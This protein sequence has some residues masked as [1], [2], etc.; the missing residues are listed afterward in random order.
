MRKIWH[1]KTLFELKKLAKEIAASVTGGEIFALNGNLGSGKTTFTKALARALKIKKHVTSPTF[2][3]MKAYPFKKTSRKLHLYHL[4]LY[5]TETN[6]VENLGLKE[7]WKDKNSITVIEW[8]N[9][10]K[11]HLPKATHQI[12]FHHT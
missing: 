1:I 2:V 6:I 10:I 5:R 4:D 12:F 9:K 8:A 11:K 7:I 3:I